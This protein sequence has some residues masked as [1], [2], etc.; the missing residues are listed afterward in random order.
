LDAAHREYLQAYETSAGYWSGINAATT[1]LLLDDRGTSAALAR[2][3]HEQCVTLLEIDTSPAG[4]YWLLATLGEAALLVDPGTT[5]SLDLAEGWYRQAAALKRGIGDVAST[6]RNARLILG[7]LGVSTA[8]IDACFAVR[9]VVVF[10]G[11]LIDSPA[12]PS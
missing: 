1:A 6:R 4:R 5:E 11:H 3:V 12:R 9:P 7:H 2:R 8:R 10:A